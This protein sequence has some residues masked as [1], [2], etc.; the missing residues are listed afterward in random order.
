MEGRVPPAG[1]DETNANP[2]VATRL[3]PQPPLPPPPSMRPPLAFH[4]ETYVIQVPKDQIY[5]IPPPENAIIA[6]R[7]RTP[8]MQKK[9]ASK[10]C[11][12]CLLAIG[13]ILI[14]LA[15]MGIVII[16]LS[17][18]FIPRA[19]TFSVV[20]VIAKNPKSSPHKHS[21]PAYDIS[22]RVNNP[23]DFMGIYYRTGGV[24]ILSFKGKKIAKGKF[25][26]LYQDLKKSTKIKV[27]LKGSHATL[28]NQI[29]KSMKDKKSKLPILLSLNVKFQVKMK[30]GTMKTWIIDSQVACTFK[31]SKLGVGS[32]ILWQK[33]QTEFES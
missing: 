30:L 3:Q 13:V 5:R 8:S 32:R 9:K 31:V 19:P 7:Y 21:Q 2:Q 17:F 11:S 18:A 33:C 23:N 1:G 10:P 14:I 29:E 24:A 20:Q 25:P 26:R 27:V 4:A 15:L 6:E 22:L 28:P 16:A 12:F